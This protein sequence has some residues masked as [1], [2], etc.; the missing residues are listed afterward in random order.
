MYQ[1][2]HCLIDPVKQEARALETYI[3]VST[4]SIMGREY[5]NHSV[6]VL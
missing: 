6:G 3:Y 2:T 5:I 1:Y 4:H